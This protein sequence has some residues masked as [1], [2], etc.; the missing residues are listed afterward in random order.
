MSPDDTFK[1][2]S[3]T[4]EVPEMKCLFSSYCS[5]FNL[6]TN[7]VGIVYFSIDVSCSDGKRKALIL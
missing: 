3:I 4:S 7:G 5:H 1:Y 6:L 2:T